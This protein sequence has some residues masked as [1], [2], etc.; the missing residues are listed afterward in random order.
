MLNKDVLG[1]DLYDFAKEFN[2]KGPGDIGDIEEARKAFWKG[3]AERIIN[4]FKNA[5]VVKVNVTTT[6]TATSHTGT[7]TGGIE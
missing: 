3:A 7:G 2:D 1:T 4:H 6:G 5:G